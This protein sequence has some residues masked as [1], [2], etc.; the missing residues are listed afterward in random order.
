MARQRPNFHRQD[1][2]EDSRRL[3][4]SAG[5]SATAARYIP[6]PPFLDTPRWSHRPSDALIRVHCFHCWCCGP[7]IS[8]ARPR[9]ISWTH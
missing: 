2:L 1:P 7:G 5:A 4:S 8:P 9:S 6:E 3:S